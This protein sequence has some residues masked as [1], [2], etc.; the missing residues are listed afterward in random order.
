MRSAPPLLIEL[1]HTVTHET[2]QNL[3]RLDCSTQ[4]MLVSA[5]ELRGRGAGLRMLNLGGGDM[6]TLMRSM[7]FTMIAALGPMEQEIKQERV[8]DSISE[9][10][11]L[12][13]SAE[14]APCGCSRINLTTR[15]FQVTAPNSDHR[16]PPKSSKN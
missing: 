15:P 7:L 3:D 16:M 8:V 10:P 11:E 5:E 6:P 14:R 1:Q 4:N 13:S 2:P 9:C 12:P